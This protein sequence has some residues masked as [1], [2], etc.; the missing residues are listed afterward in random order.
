MSVTERPSPDI[1][2]RDADINT[3]EHRRA[4]GKRLNHQPKMNGRCWEKNEDLTSAVAKS[5]ALPDSILCNRFLMCLCN[6]GW[7]SYDQ[8]KITILGIIIKGTRLTNPSGTATLA[9]PT[10][11]RTV[12]STPVSGLCPASLLAGHTMPSHSPW[13]VKGGGTYEATSASSA[14]RWAL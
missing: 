14:S 5:I 1:L 7:S 12:L 3:L 8:Y 4:K 11:S 2:A 6:L 10:P 9:L 13:N